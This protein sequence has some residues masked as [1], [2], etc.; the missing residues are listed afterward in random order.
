MHNSY[1]EEL[2]GYLDQE[3]RVLMWPSKQEK[4]SL[5]LTHLADRFEPN[6]QY[7]EREV[8]D[9]LR[10]AHLFDDHALLRRELFESGRLHR[11]PDG[12]AYWRPVD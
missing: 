4:R 2:R 5:V 1:M 7:S 11:T 6:R 8:N 12:R 10:A 3:G 9:I